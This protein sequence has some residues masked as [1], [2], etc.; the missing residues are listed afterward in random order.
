M[1]K[2]IPSFFGAVVFYTIIPISSVFSVNFCKIAVWLPWV[3]IVI[4][5]LLGLI[6]EFFTLIGIPSLTKAVLIV[7]LWI[8]IT[9]GLHLDGVMDTADGLAVQNPEKKLEVMRDS[10]TGAFGVMAG[11]VV[12][13][14]KIASVSEI[15]ENLWFNLILVS[16]WGRWGQLIAIA[17][18]LY[19][20]EKGKGAFLKENLHLPIDVIISSL[21]IIPLVITQYF[22][23]NQSFTI[24]TLTLLISITIPLLTGWWFKQQL[25][26][27]TGDTYGAT[28][29]WSEALILSVLTILDH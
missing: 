2:L 4:G 9:G 27:H 10:Q 6:A 1:K 15:T 18:Y 26:G 19:L 23:L 13:T 20:R 21:F 3:G 8:L 22:W 24:I 11:I 28:V 25:G 12:I 5:I 17:L 7:S 29:E 14:L 16:S